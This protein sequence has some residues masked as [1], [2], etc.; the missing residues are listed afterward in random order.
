L[1]VGGGT[2][3]GPVTGAGIVIALQ[4]TLADKVGSWVNVIIGVI[5]VL[6]VLAFRKGIIG[7]LQAWLERRRA[8]ASAKA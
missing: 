5:F 4:D 8:V 7:E 2:F 1:L 3:F 6:C